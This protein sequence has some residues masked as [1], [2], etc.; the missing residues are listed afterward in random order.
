MPAL[1]FTKDLSEKVL[2]G[3]KTQTVRAK[4]KRP[5]KV[6]DKLFL[7]TGMR[8]KYCRLLGI[9]I[10]SDISEIE[11]RL[12]SEDLYINDLKM[13]EEE[14]QRFAMADGFNSYKEFM[15]YFF[16]KDEDTVVFYGNVYS[17]ELKED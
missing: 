11:I 13:N 14:K 8:T 12:L 6:G 10:C 7:Y 16:E 15:N 9:G 2:H 1:N 3:I 4:R 17:W 5:I